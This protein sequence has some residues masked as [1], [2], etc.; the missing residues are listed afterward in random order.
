MARSSGKATVRTT[1][2]AA[3][4]GKISRFRSS[5]SLKEGF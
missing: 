5:K 1:Y 2:L 4:G 3:A